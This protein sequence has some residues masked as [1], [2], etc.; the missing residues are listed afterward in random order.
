MDIL[1]NDEEYEQ[2]KK[3]FV[4]FIHNLKKQKMGMYVHLTK[5]LFN[6]LL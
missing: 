2:H 3:T 4:G 6:I 1:T 5:I